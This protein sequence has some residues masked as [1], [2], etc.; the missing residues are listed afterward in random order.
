MKKLAA[1]LVVIVLF[2]GAVF[3]QDCFTTIKTDAFSGT[4]QKS[5]ALKRV[6]VVEGTACSA[7]MGLSLY[8]NVSKVTYSSFITIYVPNEA[9]ANRY[10]T[11]CVI[12][13]ESSVLL[14]FTSGEIIELFQISDRI[15]CGSLH[16]TVRT[17]VNIADYGELSLMRLNTSDARFDVKITKPL[18]YQELIEC[19]FQFVDYK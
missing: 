3:S 16:F 2:L 10:G 12:G 15:D 18:V 4:L 11:T 7:V 14:K 17:P 13:G 5:T 1:I 8:Q 19:A 9:C 6:G